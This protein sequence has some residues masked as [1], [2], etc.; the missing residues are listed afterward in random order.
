M[1]E[2]TMPVTE[3]ESL[4]LGEEERQSYELAFHILPTVAEE[5]VPAVFEAIKTAIT[6]D[7]GELFDEEVPERFVLS[8]EVVKHLEGKNRKFTSA[9]FGWVR[10]HAP[11]EA[12]AK[13]THELDI[14]ANILRYLLIKLTRVEEQ[15]PFRFH[16]ALRDQKMVTTVEQSVVVPDFTTVSE[17]EAETSAPKEEAGEVDEAALEKALGEKEV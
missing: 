3:A 13:I 4:A 14:N 1:A 2:A 15:N 9:Y 12:V 6:K 5:E 16:E 10:F 7:G 17:V 11:G 8:Y